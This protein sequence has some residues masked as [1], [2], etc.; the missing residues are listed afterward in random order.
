MR[1]LISSVSLF[2]ISIVLLNSCK[3][4][5]ASGNGSSVPA[6][7]SS[8]TCTYSGSG[9]GTFT[10]DLSLSSCLKSSSLI[11]LSGGSVSGLASVNQGMMI[12]P[13]GISVGTHSQGADGSADGVVF[14]LTI[15]N[16]TQ[17]W[18]SGG[19]TATGFTVN[20]TRNDASGIEGTFSGQL[21]NDSDNT[22][23][24]ITNGTFAG[25]F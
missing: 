3:K 10:S 13:L 15:N 17:S 7:K 14:T 6:G 11:N 22:I 24:T 18:S 25:T 8:V 1:K 5:A 16:G 12:L 19:S 2:L 4:D 23:V 9:S 20:V 21:G